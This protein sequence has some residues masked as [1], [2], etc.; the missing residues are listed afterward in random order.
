MTSP[1]SQLSLTNHTAATL[2]LA[3]DR[4]MVYRRSKCLIEV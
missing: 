3:E 1:T 2:A 4:G